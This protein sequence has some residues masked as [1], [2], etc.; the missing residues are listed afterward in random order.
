MIE[1]NN[2]LV[3]S[4]K[5]ID[6]IESRGTHAGLTRQWRS[7]IWNYCANGANLRNECFL[8]KG[9]SPTHFHTTVGKRHSQSPLQSPIIERHEEEYRF[10]GNDRYRSSISKTRKESLFPLRLRKFLEYRGQKRINLGRRKLLHL[11]ERRNRE[12]VWRVN[13]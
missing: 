4:C 7:T 5:W 1:R 10:D 11:L 2:R 13:V 12:D 3:S 8:T 6:K 9:L